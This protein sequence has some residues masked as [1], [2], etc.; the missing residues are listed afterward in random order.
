MDTKYIVAAVVVLA[1]LLA[2]SREGYSGQ[3]EA[4]RQLLPEDL[5]VP[6]QSKWNYNL[7]TPSM[8]QFSGPKVYIEK[9]PNGDVEFIKGPAQ[10]EKTIMCDRIGS[11]GMVPEFTKMGHCVDAN[12]LWEKVYFGGSPLALI[13]IPSKTIS[14]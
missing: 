14:Y 6:F 1:L 2:V 13:Y 11:G 3:A 9:S 10:G 7:P 8:F 5:V 12:D 4:I